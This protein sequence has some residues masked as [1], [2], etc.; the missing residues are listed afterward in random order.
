MIVNSFG[1]IAPQT[2][3]DHETSRRTGAERALVS[4]RNRR[5]ERLSRLTQNLSRTSAQPLSDNLAAT[6][7][8]SPDD[9]RNVSGVCWNC[10]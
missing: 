3:Q 7:R 4:A 8:T 2:V 9:L 6:R 10:Q 1:H 5:E